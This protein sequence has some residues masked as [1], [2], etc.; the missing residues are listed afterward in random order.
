MI[1]RLPEIGLRFACDSGRLEQPHY[2]ELPVRGV[3]RLVKQA[4]TGGAT[5]YP[6]VLAGHRP[7]LSRLTPPT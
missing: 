6:A 5:G 1:V 2:S 3:A 7:R 4:G